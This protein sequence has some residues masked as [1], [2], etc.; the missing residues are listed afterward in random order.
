MDGVTGKVHQ[1][2]YAVT[3]NEVMQLLVGQRG[4]VTPG[5]RQRLQPFGDDILLREVVIAD[6]FN[7]ARIE[8]GETGRK[9]ITYRVAAQVGR[10]KAH[11]QGTR[12]V[13][14]VVEARG[15]AVMRGS[16][17]LSPGAVFLEHLLRGR[18]RI[19]VEVG[20]HAGQGI[21]KIRGD[22]IQRAVMFHRLADAPQLVVAIGKVVVHLCRARIER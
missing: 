16:G 6:R 4:D 22:R 11:A 3:S 21:G 2:V 18:R 14:I 17:R 8:G 5:V 9:N 7:F 12:R 13:S 20:Q 15:G 19:I 1:D 10:N